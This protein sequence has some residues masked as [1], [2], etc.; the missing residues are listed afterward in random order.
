[1]KEKICSFCGHRDADSSLRTQIKAAIT[2]II[3]NDGVTTFY[4]G[5]MGAFDGMC[6]SD[7]R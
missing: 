3:E 7:V 5:G 6:E 4:S 2:D 1:M